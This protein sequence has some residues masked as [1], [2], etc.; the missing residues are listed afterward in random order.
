MNDFLDN[1]QP[2]GKHNLV[3]RSF[4]VG[5]QSRGCDFLANCEQD[6]AYFCMMIFGGL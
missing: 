1:K 3:G 2:C 4:S 5:K 6:T